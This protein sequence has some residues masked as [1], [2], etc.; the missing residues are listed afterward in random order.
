MVL[1]GHE[2]TVRFG[3]MLRHL[4]IG[5]RS[6]ATLL[7]LVAE[8]LVG[9]KVWTSEASCMTGS[10]AM[11]AVQGVFICIRGRLRGIEA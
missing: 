6:C 8:R 9:I 7:Y 5:V 3:N 11:R 10:I 4:L 1:L 2:R